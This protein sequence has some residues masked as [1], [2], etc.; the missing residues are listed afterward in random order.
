MPTDGRPPDWFI[1]LMNRLETDQQN[2]LVD[3]VTVI[4]YN[5]QFTQVA[6]LV[7]NMCSVL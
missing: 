1:K 2:R 5:D 6:F 3:Y 7:V 4:W